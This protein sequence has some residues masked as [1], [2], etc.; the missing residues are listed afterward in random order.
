MTGIA[1]ASVLCCGE[2]KLTPTPSSFCPGLSR[3]QRALVCLLSLPSSAGDTQGGVCGG[4]FL[5]FSGTDK[6]T[7]S[8]SQEQ[9]TTSQNCTPVH[10]RRR[11]ETALMRVSSAPSTRAHLPTVSS[12]P[13]GA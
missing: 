13:N 5:M 7:T 4:H 11:Q 9:S 2:D 6:T 3:P 12:D 1:P 10:G 8:H